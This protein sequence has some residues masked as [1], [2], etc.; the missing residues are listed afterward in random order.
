MHIRSKK[1][2]M[3][4]I[5][6]LALLALTTNAQSFSPDVTSCPDSTYR[7]N[8]MEFKCEKCDIGKVSDDVYGGTGLEC[9]C[10]PGYKNVIT[11]SEG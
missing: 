5:G 6:F 2:K 7:F 9:V 8:S 11:I 4:Q 3:A 10:A 1:Q